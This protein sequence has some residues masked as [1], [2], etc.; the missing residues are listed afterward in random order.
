MQSYQPIARKYRPKLFK[1]VVGQQI[2]TKT[3]QNA[4]KGGRVASN[5]LFSGTRG[6]GKTTIARIFARAINCENLTDALEP[7]NE[8]PS[9]TQMLSGAS[10][11]LIEIDGASNR[12]I[13]DIRLISEGVAFSPSKGRFKVYLIDEVHMLTKEAFNALLKT[14][15]EPPSYVKFFFATTEPHKV[16]LTIQSRCQKFDLQRIDVTTISQ[17]LDKIVQDQKM[18][19]DMA[20]LC[21]IADAAQ[22]SMRD[23]ESLLDQLL[24]TSQGNLTIESV[25]D[26]LGKV[27]RHSLFSL[28]IAIQGQDIKKIKEVADTLLVS[29]KETSILVEDLAE[30][31]RNHLLAQQNALDEKTYHL[32][33]E[34]FSQYRNLSKGYCLSSLLDMLE[35]IYP[36]FHQPTRPFLSQAQFETLLILLMKKYKNPG[37]H[38]LIERL[39]QLEAKLTY[40]P[41]VD[42]VNDS[43]EVLQELVEISQDS[44]SGSLSPSTTKSVVEITSPLKSEEVTLAPEKSTAPSPVLNTVRHQN[45]IQFAIVELNATLM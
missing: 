44:Q 33:S 8:C 42:P 39:E 15:E 11:D 20:A 28:D 32:S 5:Y 10:M 19:A 26:A 34:E 31:L 3:L 45:L 1:E 30:H 43:V 18:L 27:S 16:P 6:T 21:L 41:T 38:A 23:A 7:C 36:F 25:R 22:G 37:L 4:I 29:G 40:V 24:C 17:K 12:G 13:D 14:L 9:C 35:L 2:I